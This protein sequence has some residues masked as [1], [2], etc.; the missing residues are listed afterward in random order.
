MENKQIKT[1]NKT[2]S[3]KRRVINSVIMSLLVVLLI[4]SGIEIWKLKTDNT[5]LNNEIT[6]YSNNPQI[7]VQRQ[8]TKIINSV[9]SLLGS[10]V[11]TN[12][13]PTIATVTDVNAVKKE[14]SFFN[15]A[16]YGDKVLFYVKNGI[17]ILYRPSD[18]K[19]I[20]DGP[21]TFSK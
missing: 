7:L 4:I 14:A 5:N 8:T 11:P 20:A 1:V 2:V 19:I 21:L 13:T 9:Q 10:K 6:S 17:V 18:N 12:E 15:L 16:Q 3:R